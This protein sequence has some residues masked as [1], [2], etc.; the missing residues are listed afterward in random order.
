MRN[1]Y[2]LAQQCVIITSSRAEVFCKKG[3]QASGLQLYLKTDSNTVVFQLKFTKILRT[4]LFVKHLRWL[5]LYNIV[6]SGQRYTLIE[7][8]KLT[9]TANQLTGFYMSVKF[10]MYGFREN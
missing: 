9:C 10:A 5:L 4:S 2:C 8:S 6:R 3:V 1:I 7:T